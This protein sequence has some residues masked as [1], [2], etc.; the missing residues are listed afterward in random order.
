M[1]SESLQFYPGT[2]KLLSFASCQPRREENGGKLSF[3]ISPFPYN[4]SQNQISLNVYSHE[5]NEDKQQGDIF[6]M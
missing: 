4:S 5:N 6:F 1:L 3:L 2:N